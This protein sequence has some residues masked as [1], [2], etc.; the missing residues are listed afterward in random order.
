[1][2]ALSSSKNPIENDMLDSDS[3]I[4]D[5]VPNAENKSVKPIILSKREVDAAVC[6]TK[7]R[8]TSGPISEPTLWTTVE[9]PSKSI[10]L[11]SRW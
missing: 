3:A 4:Q 10:P 11:A 5:D 9:H 8:N 1:M 2:E 6:P 7:N